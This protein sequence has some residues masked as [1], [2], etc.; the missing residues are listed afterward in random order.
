MSDSG[1]KS[2]IV[3]L[4][5]DPVCETFRR[6]TS[7]PLYFCL[8]SVRVLFGCCPRIVRASR[9]PFENAFKIAVNVSELTLDGYILPRFTNMS[10]GVSVEACAEHPFYAAVLLSGRKGPKW[11]TNRGVGS[12]TPHL[13]GRGPAPKEAPDN[14][15]KRL[16]FAALYAQV[17]ST[18]AVLGEER[19]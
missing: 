13:P 3:R 7:P 11:L 10:T 18:Q 19:H 1:T 8:F 4:E 15:Y 6:G 12:Y 14:R 9:H 16:P 5:Y 17:E 2:R